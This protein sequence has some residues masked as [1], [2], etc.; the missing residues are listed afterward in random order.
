MF[1]GSFVFWPDQRRDDLPSRNCVPHYSGGLI[2]S[3]LLF[4]NSEKAAS[5]DCD[6]MPVLKSRSN[7]FFNT[8]KLRTG[9]YAFP[10]SQGDFSFVILL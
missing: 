1:N 9:H 5:F 4:S 8:Q 2:A 6:V 10:N 7:V 3:L